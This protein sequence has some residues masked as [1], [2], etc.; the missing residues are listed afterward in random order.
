[1]LHSAFSQALSKS[2]NLLK[3]LTSSPQ[4]RLYLAKVKNV[5][6]YIINK[7]GKVIGFKSL[8]LNCSDITQVI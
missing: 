7:S 6:K 5:S 1:M 3:R 2:S 4:T 8:R